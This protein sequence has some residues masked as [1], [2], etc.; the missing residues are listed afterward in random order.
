MKNR[1]G[2][3]RISNQ[4][5]LMKIVEYNKAN[6]IVVEFQD[7][8]RAKV[9]TRYEHFMD[10]SIKN[11]YCPSV[12]GVGMIGEKYPSKINNKKTKEYQ[13]WHGML[14]RCFDEKF[15]EKCPSYKDVTCCKEWLLFENFYEWLHS[16][17]NFEKWLNGEKWNVDKDILVKGNRI[18][19][20][21]RCCLVPCN[22]NNLFVKKNKNRGNLP[23]GVTKRNNR[24]F[25]QCSNFSGEGHEGLGYHI[26]SID[27]FMTYKNRKEEIIKQVA[28]EEY[29]KGNIT[30]N[31]YE[32]MMRYEVEI[33]D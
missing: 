20:S 24:F 11:P 28:Q 13:T 22:V 12:L 15:K 8:Y 26:D 32:A 19:M 29:E 14:V 16:Q 1:L 25:A 10:G 30:K 3:E 23:I 2:E 17:E 6:D 33:D 27:A 21:E 5:C 9:R 18:Y 31:C 4:G 7:E